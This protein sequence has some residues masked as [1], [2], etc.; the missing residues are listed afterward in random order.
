MHE[1][2]LVTCTNAKCSSAWGKTVL[3]HLS[4]PIITL[5]LNHLWPPKYKSPLPETWSITGKVVAVANYDVVVV[6][7]RAGARK[8]FHPHTKAR[9]RAT[10]TRDIIFCVAGTEQQNTAKN[11]S[12]LLQKQ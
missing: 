11:T 9:A 4:F 5:L 8:S 10:R 7:V 12:Q 6:S 3:F 1:R 2:A